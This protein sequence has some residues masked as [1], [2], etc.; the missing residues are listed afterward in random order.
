MA[1]NIEYEN[2]EQGVTYQVEIDEQTG[3]KEKVISESRNKKVVP[4]LLINDSKG[5][6]VRTYNLT[7]RCSLDG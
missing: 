6:N 3:F 1:V 2:I 5:N 4:T 7:S